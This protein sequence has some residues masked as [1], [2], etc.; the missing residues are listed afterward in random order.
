[1]THRRKG[2]SSNG[3]AVPDHCADSRGDFTVHSRP[4]GRAGAQNSKSRSTRRRRKEGCTAALQRE[5]DMI[6]R[7]YG[8]DRGWTRV[9]G[10]PSNSLRM[11]EVV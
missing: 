4:E 6:F 7:K 5:R 1:M 9:R 8:T 10:A 2:P 3:N 11:R